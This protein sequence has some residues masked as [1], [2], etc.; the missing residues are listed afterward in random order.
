MERSEERL[1][2]ATEKLEEASKAADESERYCS[3]FYTHPPFCAYSVI[4]TPSTLRIYIKS[5]I[6]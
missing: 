6:L 3:Q 4:V 5:C 1:Q 2:S